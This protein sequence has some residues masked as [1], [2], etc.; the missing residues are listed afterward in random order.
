[1]SEIP[2]RDYVDRMLGFERD[3]RAHQI[4]EAK[5]AV[6]IARDEVNRR[7]TEMNNLREQINSER[8]HFLS[9][10]LFEQLEARVRA[11]ENFRS[12]I[13]GRIITM[14]GVFVVLQLLIGALLTWMLRKP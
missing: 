10:D 5:S 6:D 9:R 4:A 1:M 7:L 12:N 2:L 8:G 11:V 13:D 3:L 14:G